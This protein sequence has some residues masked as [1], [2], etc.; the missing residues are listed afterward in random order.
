MTET[1][2]RDLGGAD[3]YE[4]LGVASDA[5]R[6]EIVRAHRRR[7]REVHPDLPAGDAER[8]KLL[9]LARD[10]LLDPV[11]RGDYDRSLVA[12]PAPDPPAAP[13]EPMPSGVWETEDVIEGIGRSPLRAEPRTPPP[14]MRPPTPAYHDPG[15]AVYDPIGYPPYP[16]PYE[17]GPYP[18][19]APAAP[20]ETLTLPIAALVSALFCGPIG[21]LLGLIALGKH[22][23]Y[24]GAGRVLAITA[25]VIG[26][27]SLT[28]CLGQLGLQFFPSLARGGG[29]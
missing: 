13:A 18:A 28:W 4:V 26:V 9:H 3:P 2:R 5:T 27:V 1:W 24:P 29:N 12:E 6:D 15:P 8:T 22:W 16:P 20:Q 25:V 11:R 17:P 10:V 23:R 14:P 21:L 7:V 19:P